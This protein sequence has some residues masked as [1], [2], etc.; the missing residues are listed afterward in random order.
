MADKAQLKTDT[1]ENIEV[2]LPRHRVALTQ[3]YRLGATEVAIGQFKRFV[4]A[5]GYKTEAEKFGF[6][7]SRL[8]KPDETI[9]PE[10]KKMNWRAPGPGWWKPTDEWPVTQITWNDAVAFCNW[11]SEQEKLKAIRSYVIY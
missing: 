6:G 8:E 10:M 1:T 9:T 7:Q 2:E 5:A 3:P 4:E 11:L